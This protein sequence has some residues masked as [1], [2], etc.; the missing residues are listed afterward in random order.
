MFNKVLATQDRKMGVQRIDKWMNIPH[1]T[2]AYVAYKNQK[3][4]TEHKVSYK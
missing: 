2:D 4:F 3:L 1:Y